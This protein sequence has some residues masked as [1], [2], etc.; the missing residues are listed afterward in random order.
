M[1]STRLCNGHQASNNSGQKTTNRKTN[2]VVILTAN[3]FLPKGLK[4]VGFD[5]RRQQNVQRIHY[6][7]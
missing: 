3:E 2:M 5:I 6:F 4:L 1:N 7:S